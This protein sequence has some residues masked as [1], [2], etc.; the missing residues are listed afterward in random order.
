VPLGAQA[1]RAAAGTLLAPFH[2][3]SHTQIE[4]PRGGERRSKSRT[5]AFVVLSALLYGS[6]ASLRRYRDADGALRFEVAV[7]PLARRCNVTVGRCADLLRWLEGAS[8]LRGLRIAQGIASAT[9]VPLEPTYGHGDAGVEAKSSTNSTEVD[10]TS[11][12]DAP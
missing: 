9:L 12:E 6:S 10:P 8:L 5:V 7:S 2:R 4:R 11:T 1:L 3:M